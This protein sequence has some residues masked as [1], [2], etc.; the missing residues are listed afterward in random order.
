MVHSAHST[1]ERHNHLI[2]TLPLKICDDVKRS[3]DTTL[4]WAKAFVLANGGKVS[5]IDP[6]MFTM[7]ENNSFI[8]VIIVHVDDFLFAGN[9]KFQNTVIAHLR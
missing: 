6:S 5:E 4:A 1:S 8:E 2:T 9:E 7:H 3:Y